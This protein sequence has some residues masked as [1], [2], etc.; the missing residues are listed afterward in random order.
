MRARQKDVAALAGVAPKTVS[1]VINNYEHVSDEIRAR[2]FAAI[3]EL[4]YRPNLPARSLRSGRS[5]VIALSL[6]DLDNPYFAELA[7]HIVDAAAKQSWTVVLDRSDAA[8]LLGTDN[9]AGIHGWLLDG[10]ILSGPKLDPE[11]L[12][13][14][15]AGTPL[16]LLSDPGYGGNAPHVSIDN[17]AAARTATEHLVSTGRRRVAAIG[18]GTGKRQSLTRRRLAGYRSALRSA[19]LTSEPDLVPPTFGGHRTDGAAA[20][21]LLLELKDRPDAIFCFTDLLAFGAMHTLRR[22]G[23]RVPED[24]AVIGIDDIDEGRYSAPTLSTIAPDREALAT[25]VIDALARQ[26]DRRG[27]ERVADQVVPF[28]LVVREST[29]RRNPARRPPRVLR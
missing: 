22:Y 2:V 4:G 3:E 29:T 24:V 20:A 26:V 8:G 15:V 9:A 18:V 13:K 12:Q 1:N 28:E 23:V 10:I 25:A 17:F 16:V 14:R 5:G 11:T 7:K 21:E 27:G 19:G 6:R